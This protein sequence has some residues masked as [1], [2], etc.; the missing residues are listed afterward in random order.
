[1]GRPPGFLPP[2]AV[3]GARRWLSHEGRMGA[4]GR[5][6]GGG[7]GLVGWMGLSISSTSEVSEAMVGP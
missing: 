7:E 1:M 6:R 4:L 5:G 3:W 2:P